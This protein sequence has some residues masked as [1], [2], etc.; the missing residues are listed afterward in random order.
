M[1]DFIASLFITLLCTL[2]P[3]AVYALRKCGINDFNFGQWL[4]VNRDRFK[5]GAISD[6]I[7]ASVLFFVPE[8]GKIFAAS[9][10]QVS[11]V[12]YGLIGVAVGAL[13]VAAIG[14]RREKE[15]N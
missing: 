2:A 14:G 12:T 3:L 1:F 15:E 10:L 8:A 7:F 4:Y 6:L 9:G 5:I 11:S 13:L